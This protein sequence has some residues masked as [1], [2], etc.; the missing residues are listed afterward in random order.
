[1]KKPS[2]S[3][4]AKRSTRQQRQERRNFQIG[5]TKKNAVHPASA[6]NPANPTNPTPPPKKVRR[7]SYK[8]TDS[9]IDTL[10]RSISRSTD[11]PIEMHCAVCGIHRDTYHQWRKIALEE[12]GGEHARQMERVDK[13]LF[14]AWGRLHEAAVKHKASEVL[15]RR[16]HDFYP[17][18][19]QIME[20]SGAGGLPLIPATENSFCVVLELDPLD[21]PLE[22][23]SF[24]I[25]QPD[26]N[27]QVRIPPQTNGQEKPE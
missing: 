12:P 24:K 4:T 11:A 9:R 14:E 15:F 27:E 17:S 8:L 19:R 1:M 20:I 6:G 5:G 2:Q 23:R 22:Q 21:E 25:V 10:V 3:K 18:E 13:A 7:G 16:H 26:G